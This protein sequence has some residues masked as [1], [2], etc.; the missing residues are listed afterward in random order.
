[1][2]QFEIPF[3]VLG[4]GET[5][6]LCSYERW[7]YVNDWQCY[8]HMHSFTEIFFITDGE[9]VFHTRDADF[10]VRRGNV[11]INTPS[12][13]HTERPSEKNP[14]AYAVFC[15]ENLTFKIPNS[16]QEK[17]FV[18]D[19]SAYYD[20]LHKV[21]AVVEREYMEKLPI[22]QQAVLN[23]FNSFMLFLLRNTNLATLPFDSSAKSNSISSIRHFLDAHYQENLNLDELSRRF[24]LN[25]FYI[26]HAFNKKYGVSIMRY[27]NELRC[28]E[29]EH[30]LQTTNLSVTEISI[31]IGYNS[32]AAFTDN[33][34]KIIGETPAETR[35]KFFSAPPA[36]T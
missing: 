9:G 8:E 4:S 5:Y 14:L 36:E 7:S 23:E 25:K 33:Y 11:I 31:S 30:L 24:F 27:L 13:V 26:S 16:P 32:A 19:F 1:M 22:W 35:R 10:P 28:K 34:K 3:R 15:V 18:F 12:V 20:Q 17:T 2:R 29:G 6:N 21:L